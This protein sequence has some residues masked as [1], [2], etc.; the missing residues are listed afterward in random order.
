MARIIISIEDKDDVILVK[1]VFEPMVHPDIE[2]TPAQM[3]AGEIG[4]FITEEIGYVDMKFVGKNG[5]TRYRKSK[6]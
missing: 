3:L 6:G 1:M 2:Y 5:E 4:N